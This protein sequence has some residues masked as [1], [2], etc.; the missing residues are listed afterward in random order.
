MK[1]IS[2]KSGII[3]LKDIPTYFVPVFLYTA[4]TAVDLNE[5]KQYQ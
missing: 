1:K 5:I 3:K 4:I 2:A